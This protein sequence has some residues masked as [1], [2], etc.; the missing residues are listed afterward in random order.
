MRNIDALTTVLQIPEDFSGR[1]LINGS[2]LHRTTMANVGLGGCGCS[3]IQK[4]TH[5]KISQTIPKSS[6]EKPEISPITLREKIKIIQER[7]EAGTF[8]KMD[9][10]QG[11]FKAPFH[12]HTPQGVQHFFQV[13]LKK[14]M[15]SLGEE[16][17]GRAAN[18]NLKYMGYGVADINSPVQDMIYHAHEEIFGKQGDEFHEV[19]R[20]REPIGVIPNS[21]QEQIKNWKVKQSEKRK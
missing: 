16:K 21:R 1:S 7:D 9:H 8:A 2:P 11:I 4:K 18:G 20:S 14:I 10:S 6:R 17:G 19:K 13:Y 5:N 15:I 3:P 12:L